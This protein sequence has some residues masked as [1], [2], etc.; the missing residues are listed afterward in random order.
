MHTQSRLQHIHTTLCEHTM[1]DITLQHMNPYI[2]LIYTQTALYGPITKIRVPYSDQI[3]H[4]KLY[5]RKKWQIFW[6]QQVHNK[7][8]TASNIGMLST[9]KQRMSLPS[10]YR[11]YVPDTQILAGWGRPTSQFLLSRM[12]D[13]GIHPN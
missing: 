8:V 7:L 9:V 6:D 2:S 3:V 4:L 10:P 11:S 13:S 5:F 12:F 1:L